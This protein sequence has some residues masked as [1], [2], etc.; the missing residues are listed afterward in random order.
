MKTDVT[1]LQCLVDRQL[2]YKFSHMLVFQGKGVITE[3]LAGALCT[4]GK[5]CLIY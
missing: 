3:A 1:C 5:Y 2:Q 4:G